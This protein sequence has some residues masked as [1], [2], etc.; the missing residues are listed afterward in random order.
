MQGVGLDDGRQMGEGMSEAIGLHK[1]RLSQKGYSEK[2][3][4][5][6]EQW[7]NEHK[8]D[9]LLEGLMFRPHACSSVFRCIPEGSFPI[10]PPTERDRIIAETV[11][12]W[13]G[14]NCGMSFLES[15]LNRAGFTVKR[16]DNQ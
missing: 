15:S 16:K 1:K 13:L 10:G 12:Q 7:H 6:V 4:A 8:H 14:T 5:F 11:I 2:E 3:D 9:N